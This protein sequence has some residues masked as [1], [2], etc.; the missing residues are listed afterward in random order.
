VWVE[1]VEEVEQLLEVVLQRS[2]R[3]EQLVLEIVHTQ[4]PK[5]LQLTQN[6]SAGTCI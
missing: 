3:Q 6:T 1:E 5:E 4:N 2:A